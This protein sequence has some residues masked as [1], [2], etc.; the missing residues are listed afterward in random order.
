MSAP[1]T[2]PADAPVS[3]PVR[4]FVY[5]TLLAGEPNHRRLSEDAYGDPAR[6]PAKLLYRVCTRPEFTL[7]NLGY[8][9][10]VVAKGGTAVA[11]E[12]Y[13][14]GAEVLAALDR[15]EG[16][17]HHYRREE[18]ILAD[19]TRAWIYVY[20]HEVR[21]GDVDYDGARR[22]ASGDW[23]SVSPWRA[24]QPFAESLTR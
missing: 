17:P 15:L 16:H 21:D 5:G 11:G 10:G 14:V 3:F 22:I 8:F 1:E 4:V 23:R 20:A 2:T 6:E 7:Y 19:G 24:A 12:V 18:R 13:E 9:P